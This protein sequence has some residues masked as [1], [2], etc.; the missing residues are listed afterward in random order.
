M[1]TIYII[2]F[3]CLIVFSCDEKENIQAKEQALELK[4]SLQNIVDNNELLSK[5]KLDSISELE[6]IETENKVVFTVQIAALKKPNANIED[7]QKA[8][9]YNEGEFTKYRLG[10][11]ETYREARNYRKS[12]L[13]KYPDAFVQAL[14]KDQPIH[15]SKALE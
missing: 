3:T 13:N 6:S 2:F 1:R 4:D 9:V 12:L 14:K 15:I 11:F 8:D 10:Y 7:L 5:K